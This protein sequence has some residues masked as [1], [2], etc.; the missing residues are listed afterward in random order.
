MNSRERIISISS[1]RHN[2]KITKRN[3]KSENARKEKIVNKKIKND[4]K[5]KIQRTSYGRQI[6]QARGQNH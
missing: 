6:N 4:M 2:R 5:F 3:C 1:L